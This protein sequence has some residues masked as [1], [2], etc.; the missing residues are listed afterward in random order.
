MKITNRHVTV[1]LLALLLAAC[2]SAELPE[3]A[4][5]GPNPEIPPPSK[6]LFPAINIAPAG[7]WQHGRT[8]VQ[9]LGSR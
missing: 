9:P 6:A 2:D 1:F 7:S 4:T 5:E 8:P 3:A